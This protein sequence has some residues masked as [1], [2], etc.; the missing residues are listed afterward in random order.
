M[1]L[2]NTYSK[3]YT[4]ELAHEPP[5]FKFQD[6]SFAI[7]FNDPDKEGDVHGQM[8][9]IGDTEAISKNLA[10]AMIEDEEIAAVLL[11]AVDKYIDMVDPIKG[12]ET[13][14]KATEDKPKRATQAT[15]TGDGEPFELMDAAFIVTGGPASE[16]AMNKIPEE[17]RGYRTVEAKMLIQGGDDL[18]FKTLASAIQRSEKVRYIVLSALKHSLFNSTTTTVEFTEQ[19]RKDKRK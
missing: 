4:K 13:F 12:E 15:N 10:D 3:D 17:K 2:T 19:F 6:H 9:L 14:N 18:L 11:L 5:N 8:L 7:T 16:E 1:E